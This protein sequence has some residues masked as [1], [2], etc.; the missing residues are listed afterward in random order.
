MAQSAM[1]AADFRAH[2]GSGGHQLVFL[3]ATFGAGVL[4]DPKFNGVIGQTLQ[5]PDAGQG[6]R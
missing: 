3:C 2:L 4:P 1:A 6:F 5:G